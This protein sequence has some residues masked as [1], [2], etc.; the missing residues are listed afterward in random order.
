LGPVPA[1]QLRVRLS[2]DD[3]RDRASAYW[4]LHARVYA[5]KGDDRVFAYRVYGG[6]GRDEIEGQRLYGGRGR[7]VLSGLAGV[8][9]EILFGGPGK[10]RVRGLGRLYGG[11][12]DDFLDDWIGES[13]DMMVGG[14]GRDRVRLED[15]GRQDVVR[16]RGDGVDRVDCPRR[17]GLPARDVLFVDPSDRLSPSCKHAIVLYTERPRYPYP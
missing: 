13:K 3:G 6:D 10:D 9:G 4:P 15:D 7:D 1:D 5:G 12:G 2:L 17:P 11:P 16:V 14:P 8:G